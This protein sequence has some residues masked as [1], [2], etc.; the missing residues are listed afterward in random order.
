MLTLKRSFV[1]LGLVGLILL[2][3]LLSMLVTPQ[4]VWGPADFLVAGTLLACT[5][6]LV[7]LVLRKSKTSRGRFWL[8]AG[9]FLVF[10]LVWI[11]LAV[12]LFGSPW[13]GN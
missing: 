7:D 5:G 3:P 4:V 1:I 12:G 11:E 8:T 2:V 9:I 13:A 6:F 10:A